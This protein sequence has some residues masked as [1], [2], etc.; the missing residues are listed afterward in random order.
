MKSLARVIKQTADDIK[1][2]LVGEGPESENLKKQACKLGLA[3][4]VI[5]TGRLSR[6]DLIR[7][8]SGA[9]LFV[10]G[11]VTET[12]GLV[13]GEAKA[14]GLP[15]LAVDAFGVSN[16]VSNG[17]DGFLVPNNEQIFAS[18]LLYVITNPELRQRLSQR[19]LLNAREISSRNCAKKL[20]EYYYEILKHFAGNSQEKMLEQR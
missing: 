16:M 13:I 9:D 17:E 11:S 15:V 4:H 14:A 3:D 20:I 18:K 12:Q 5:F 1:L 19:A 6:E 10:F 8:Y 7:A 2:V